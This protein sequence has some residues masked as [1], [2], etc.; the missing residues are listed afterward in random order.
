MIAGFNEESTTMMA[1]TIEASG[2]CIVAADF[3]G[4]ADYA[5]VPSQVSIP[6]ITAVEVVNSLWLVC[7]LP[8]QSRTCLT[9]TQHCFSIAITKT[10]FSYLGGFAAHL[11]V[12]LLLKLFII[13]NC[14]VESVWEAG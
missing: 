2:G 6:N 9:D 1:E 4:V 3:T 10:H 8:G 13:I 14:T 7:T 12:A 11:V 5:V